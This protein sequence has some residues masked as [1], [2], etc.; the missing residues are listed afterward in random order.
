MSRRIIIFAAVLTAVLLGVFQVSTQFGSSEPAELS[1]ARQLEWQDLVPPAEPLKDALADTPMNVR[2]DLGFIGKVLADADAH[3]ISRD[4]PEFRNAMSLLE[5]HRADGIDVDKLLAS[6]TGRDEE[7]VARGEAVNSE[8]DGELVRLPGYALPLEMTEGGVKEFLLVP[9]VGACIHVPPPPPNQV[10]LAQLESAY[11]VEA[12]FDPVLITG[13]LRA[14]ST[15]SELYLVDG[16]AQVPMGYS[17]EVMH[18]EP[19]EGE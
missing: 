17:M 1:E 14:Q 15:S 4:G 7:L 11:Q 18:V 19:M 9:F 3:V 8:L 6:V 10:V 12:L 5:K 13:H 2:F 16:E